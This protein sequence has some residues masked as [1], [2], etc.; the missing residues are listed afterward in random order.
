MCLEVR[1]PNRRTV[2]D[3]VSWLP[4]SATYLAFYTP[5]THQD[6]HILGRIPLVLDIE[7]R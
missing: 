1:L 4:K 6:T 7:P 3:T 2:A 5:L